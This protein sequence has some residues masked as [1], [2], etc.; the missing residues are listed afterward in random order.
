MP[1]QKRTDTDAKLE[2]RFVNLDGSAYNTTGLVRF[3]STPH[4]QASVALSIATSGGFA[5][6]AHP[7]QSFHDFAV[8]FILNTAAITFSQFT[9]KRNADKLAKANKNAVI[10][11]LGFDGDEL[12][13]AKIIE[14]YKSKKLFDPFTVGLCAANAYIISDGTTDVS[15]TLSAILTGSLLYAMFMTPQAWGKYAAHMLTKGKWT[16]RSE[17]PKSKKKKLSPFGAP[18]VQPDNA[19]RFSQNRLT[20]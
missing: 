1:K 19:V 20:L 15:R 16:V 3:L 18:Q 8:T 10:D 6:A 2:A 7:G 17:P 12:T 9:H 11:K 13:K 5:I 4:F 14:S